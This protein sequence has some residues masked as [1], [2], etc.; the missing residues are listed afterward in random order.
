MS[1][2]RKEEIIK[3]FVDLEDFG[4]ELFAMA[5][6]APSLSRKQKKVMLHSIVGKKR[7]NVPQFALISTATAF[8]AFAF[9]FGY[10]QM[11]NAPQFLNSLRIAKPIEQKVPTPQEVQQVQ[12]TLV[13]QQSKIEELEKTGASAADIEKAVN[14][15][16][17]TVKNTQKDGYEI[18]KTI[19]KDGKTILYVKPS[20]TWQ[21]NKEDS[22][23]H[24]SDSD[25][26]ESEGSNSGE[27]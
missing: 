24:S 18:T 22:G 23:S 15:L 25:K 5:A 2:S 10:A 19:D 11:T 13:Q 26:I 14:K 12:Q 20:S 8:A 16:N 1:P 4:E 27:H 21:K 7:W 6:D 9:L 17:S 3:Q